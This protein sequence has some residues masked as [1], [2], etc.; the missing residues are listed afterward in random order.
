MASIRPVESRDLHDVELLV[1]A[2]LKGWNRDAQF[3]E[4]TLFNDPW[5]PAEPCSLVAVDDAGRIVG[6]IGAQRRRLL[7]DGQ[8]HDGVAVSHLVV[9]AEERGGATGALLVR[10]L[11][12]GRQSLTFSDSST[13]GVM[14]IWRLFGGHPD[15]T[16]NI[17]YM[18]VTR[19]DRWV[20]GIAGELVRRHPL[21]RRV[22][23]VES[24]PL[25]AIG[26]H[27]LPRAYRNAT[28]SRTPGLR[29]EPAA[30][31]EL[32]GMEGVLDRRVRLRVAHDAEYLEARFAHIESIPIGG[33]LIRRL[34]RR[35]GRPIGWFAYIARP[36]VSRVLAVHAQPDDAAAVFEALLLDAT[37]RGTAVVS[38]RSAPHL[39]EPLRERRAVLRYEAP[40]LIHARDEELRA[41]LAAPGSLLEELELL[42]CA[43]W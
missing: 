30:A 22:V 13:A 1:R 10:T 34:V 12:S 16:R 24:L 21:T 37:E 4:K 31:A 28:R 41:T 42:D 29:S 14:R 19:T 11:L 5:T 33:D 3:L 2:G 43:Y 38:G 27:L 8:E 36:T 40:P 35:S 17:E 39:A 32:A 15:M 7:F 26:D 25:H 6:S 9:A 18:I 20:R 23:P